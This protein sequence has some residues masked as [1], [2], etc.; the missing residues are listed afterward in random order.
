MALLACVCWVVDRL[1]RQPHLPATRLVRLIAVLTAVEFVGLIRIAIVW[2]R[3][4]TGDEHKLTR[5]L[6]WYTQTL[7]RGVAWAVGTT[8]EWHGTEHAATGPVVVAARHT[9]FFDAV[10]PGA[11]LA[12]H[13]HLVPLHVVTKGLQYGPCIDIVGHWIP[14]VFISR[15]PEAGSAPA[16][17]ADLA[18]H[19]TTESAAVIFPEGTFRNPARFE[20]AVNRVASTPELAARAAQLRHVLPPRPAG[21][22]TLLQGNPEA[23]LVICANTGLERWGSLR[24]IRSAGTAN[25]PIQIG[26]WRIDRKHIPTDVDE[27]G[28]WFLDQ[29]IEVDDWVSA[30]A[31]TEFEV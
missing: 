26:A 21:T 4:S 12:H 25:A 2:L 28:I 24:Q 22:W 16:D 29:W 7:L 14:T 10:I 30:R 19:L 8:I 6:G 23:D 9:S 31:Q 5:L 17:I 1:R 15:A 11:L 18:T 3:S 13:N 20:R 27:F